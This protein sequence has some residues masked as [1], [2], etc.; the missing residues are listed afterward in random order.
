MSAMSKPK[1]K[2][3]FYDLVTKGQNSYL[4]TRADI[5]DTSVNFLCEGPNGNLYTFSQ[6]RLFRI[7]KH[8][9][10][11][12]IEPEIK[13]PGIHLNPPIF[14]N[15][16]HSTF[17]LLKNNPDP[18]EIHIWQFPDSNG[19]I[20]P[21]C[22][23]TINKKGPIQ[24]L[25]WS[26]YS[27]YV[28]AFI[29]SDTVYIVD[30]R[31]IKK[32]AKLSDSNIKSFPVRGAV[33]LCFGSDIDPWLKYCILVATNVREDNFIQ[34]I[35]GLLPDKLFIDSETCTKLRL[36]LDGKQSSI[37]TAN[38][39]C[40]GTNFIFQANN[41]KP[42]MFPLKLQGKFSNPGDKHSIYLEG[43]HLILVNSNG[44]STFSIDEKFLWNPNAKTN[45]YFSFIS[46]TLGYPPEYSFNYI[47]HIQTPLSNPI[48]TK[49]G[50]LYVFTKQEVYI[51]KQQWKKHPIG[52]ICKFPEDQNVIGVG[53]TY[54]TPAVVLLK[55]LKATS[56]NTTIVPI[57]NTFLF[58]ENSEFD[59]SYPYSENEI[60]GIETYLKTAIQIQSKS[61]PGQDISKSLN[62]LKKKADDLQKELQIEIE[63]LHELFEKAQS[64]MEKWTNGQNFE[65][66]IDYAKQ[67]F[68]KTIIEEAQI[69][70]H[71]STIKLMNSIRQNI[72]NY[73]Y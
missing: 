29:H 6:G 5:V 72:G 45:T 8:Q 3:D 31:T 34:I 59:P 50:N 69:K 13:I 39:V 21:E 14:S 44:I 65:S 67:D 4:E 26:P 10:A 54:D 41:I 15:S 32:H 47:D 66:P 40:Q 33:S 30:Y 62:E 68:D 73:D 57:P 16:D 60:K 19:I 53:S 38:L 55:N 37:F 12:Y 17:I 70:A 1:Q 56:K 20:H 63:S 2:V 42:I 43:K 27:P 11:T 22:S 25:T 46:G 51:Y 48:L 18:A 7:N 61:K 49:V 36:T 24:S 23:I 71:N 58:D 28:F 9:Y 35:T 64:E 52:K